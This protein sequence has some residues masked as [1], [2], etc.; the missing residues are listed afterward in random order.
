VRICRKWRSFMIRIQSSNSR[1]SVCDHPF[2]DR[3]RPRCSGWTG[4]DPDAVRGEDRIESSGKPGVP[5]PEQEPQAEGSVAEAHQQ[6][7][8]GLG[9]P[10][11]ARVRA[12]SDQKRSAG[13][14]LDRDQRVDPPEQHGYP[15]GLGNAMRRADL[16]SS[17]AG[18]SWMIVGC[19]CC[20]RFY[21]C[22]DRLKCFLLSCEAVGG[23]FM[24]WL[25]CSGSW[26]R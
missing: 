17:C 18:R 16:H 1:G 10:R 8:S 4:K 23:W 19:C 15:V 12:H 20:R 25:W 21:L 9:G 7:A 22:Q 5:I 2:T 24:R 13:A 14:M 11:T 26:R 3:V 6:V